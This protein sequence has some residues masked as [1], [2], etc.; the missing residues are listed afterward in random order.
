M[1]ERKIRELQKQFGYDVLQALINSGAAWNSG[2]SVTK[3]CKEALVTGACFLPYKEHVINIFISVPSR[4][5]VS[6]NSIGSLN[7]SKKYWSDHWNVSIE[8]AKNI[9]Q[10]LTA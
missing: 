4:Y 10:T 3:K 7:R 5:Q 6:R 2:G 1:N 8:I 9:T